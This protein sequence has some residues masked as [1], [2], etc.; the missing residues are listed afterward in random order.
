L[1]V[2]LGLKYLHKENVIHGDLKAVLIHVFW[3]ANDF[4]L[5]TD[6]A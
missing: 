6:I 1:D 4:S 3:N 5:I 2:A